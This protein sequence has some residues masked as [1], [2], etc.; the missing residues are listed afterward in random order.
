MTLALAASLVEVGRVDAARVSAK[1]AERYE[2]WRG[3]GGAAHR[4]MRALQQ[5]ADYRGTGRLQFP[6]GSFANGGA[7]RIA[8]V[9]LAYRHASAD[10]LRQAVADAVL[11]THVHPEGIDGA[12]VQAKAV[13]LA[14]TT[15]DPSHFASVKFLTELLAVSRTPIMQAKLDS[16]ENGLAAGESDKFVIAQVGNG[17]RASEAVAAALW[18]VVRYWQ[19]P[20]ECV[21]RAVN[22]GGDTDTIGAMA[23]AIV[24]ALHGSPW[25]PARWYDNI[26][27]GEHGRDE[28][29]ALGRELAKLNAD[30]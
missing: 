22:F 29:I 19:K 7:M 12:V 16:L 10:V 25:I 24:G 15:S 30:T 20:E 27:N 8:P 17:I 5:G 11:C 21:I 14:A 9:G 3:Y 6:E 2:G 4:V 26:E 1:Y 28:M 18:A 13:A 23:G